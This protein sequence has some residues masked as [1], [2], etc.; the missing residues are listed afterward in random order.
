M[1]EKT[2]PSAELCPVCS[3]PYPKAF[4]QP[5]CDCVLL[6]VID[7]LDKVD[8]P[9]ENRMMWNAVDGKIYGGIKSD[10]PKKKRGRPRK[11]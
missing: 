1:V 11:I 7:A 9:T 5:L 4:G 10:I 2:H 8:V 6:A 3:R